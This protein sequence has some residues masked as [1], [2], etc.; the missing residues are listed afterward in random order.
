MKVYIAGPMRGLPG[1]NFPAFDAAETRWRS[2]GHQPFSPAQ[3]DRVLQYGPE[4][5]ESIAHLRHVIQL[6]LACVL[7]SDAIALLPGWQRSRGATAELS[8]ALF[9]GLGVYD[10]VTLQPIHVTPTPWAEIAVTVKPLNEWPYQDWDPVWEQLQKRAEERQLIT[11]RLQTLPV[12]ISC[13]QCHG[14]GK[15]PDYYGNLVNVCGICSGVG[16]TL[17]HTTQE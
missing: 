16:S 1:W 7:N 3:I 14:V 4:D 2:A 17:K 11:A 12:S 10:A 8:L 15:L 6:D 9:L 13:S 5:G